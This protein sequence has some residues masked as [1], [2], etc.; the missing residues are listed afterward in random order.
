MLLLKCFIPGDFLLE[1]ETPENPIG[2]LIDM[3]ENISKDPELLHP[4]KMRDL[5]PSSEFLAP[6]QVKLPFIVSN[7]LF[8]AQELLKKEW[9]IKMLAV[10]FFIAHEKGFKFHA[11]PQ[12]DAYTFSWF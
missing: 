10:F 11:Q 6:A 3:F 1:L 7:I 8:W 5:H 2:T 12:T 4:E 9:Q